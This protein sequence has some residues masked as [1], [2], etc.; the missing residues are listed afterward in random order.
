MSIPRC[1]RSRSARF[2]LPQGHTVSKT[3]IGLGGLF[4]IAQWILSKTK[5]VLPFPHRSIIGYTQIYAKRA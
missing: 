4:I 5:F 3:A 1:I 2:P